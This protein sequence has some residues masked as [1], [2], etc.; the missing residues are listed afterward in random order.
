MEAPFAEMPWA[1]QAPKLAGLPGWEP[2][3]VVHLLVTGSRPNGRSPRAPMPPFRMT[4]EDARAVVAY[5]QSY[6]R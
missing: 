2:D 1:F 3:E 4:E 6:G 5:L